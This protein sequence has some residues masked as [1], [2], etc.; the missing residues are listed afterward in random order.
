MKDILTKEVLIELLEIDIIYAK[1]KEQY[2]QT[3]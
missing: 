1:A 3:Y 2:L